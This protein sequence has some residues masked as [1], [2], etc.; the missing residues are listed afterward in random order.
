MHE[1]GKM[2]SIYP[3]ALLYNKIRFTSN[4]RTAV[5]KS[6][7]YYICYSGAAI[8]TFLEGKNAKVCR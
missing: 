6:E 5:G 8:S 3:G 1:S 7:I 4:N 2:K